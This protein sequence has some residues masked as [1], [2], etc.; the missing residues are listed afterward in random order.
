MK[1]S[2]I[3]PVYNRAKYL[4]EALD[5]VI[6]QSYDNYEIII[7]DD[8]STDA[9]FDIASMYAANLPKQIKVFKQINSGPSRAK[10]A[11]IEFSTGEFIAFL[12]SDDT[13]HCNK[14]EEQVEIAKK[15]DNFSFIYTGYNIIDSNG[16]ILD[17]IYPDKRFSGFIHDKMWLINNTI[18]GGTILVKKNNLLRI[19]GFDK[20][21]QGAE[22]LD[23]RLRLSKMG[24]VY[25]SNKLLYNYRK[26]E[27]NLSSQSSIMNTSHLSLINKNFV[28]RSYFTDKL[29]RKVMS[30]YYYSL[31]AQMHNNDID[32][33]KIK[34]ML[35]IK[36]IVLDVSRIDTF[37][38]FIK[39]VCGVK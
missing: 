27:S 37:K 11:G 31:A 3:L 39:V 13:W 23:L 4:G 32:I 28:G 7:I 18:S 29:F 6:R 8:G 19:K 34:L 21:L 5:S 12:D 25:Y 10:N 26:H 15:F 30:K 2:V 20:N 17:Q 9:S 16:N 33:K 1:I 14:L 22:N 38:L 36:S 35:I 24:P